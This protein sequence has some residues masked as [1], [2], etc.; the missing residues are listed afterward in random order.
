LSG[1][2]EP[3]R[4]N[5]RFSGARFGLAALIAS[6]IISAL[7]SQ[8]SFV[9]LPWLVLTT[10]GDPKQMGLVI[11]A[12][13]IPYLLA[14]IFGTPFG[15]R[16]GARRSAVIADVVSMLTLAVIAAVPDVDITVIM[17]SVAIAG[18]VR[19]VGDRSKTVLLRP[20]AEA[21]GVQISRMTA[22][23]SA[24]ANG[25]MLVGAPI[26]GLLIYWLGAQRALWVDA[27]S[28]GVCAL[29][30]VAFVH[31]PAELLPERGQAEPYLTAVRGGAT[32]LLGDRLLL[33]MIGMIFLTNAVNQANS[34]LFV[35]LWVERVLGS[36]A[37]LG[38]IYGAFG[39]GALLGNLVFIAL[40][41]KLPKFLTFALC[42]AVS[43]APRL[44]ALAFSHDLKLVL[45]L[46]FV[47]GFAVA[48]VN[49]ILG[50][51]LYERVPKELQ[52][53]VFGVAATVTFAGFPVGG[54]LGGWAVVGLGLTG[55]LLVGA[56][57]YLAAT[58]VPLLRARAAEQAA[59]APTASTPTASTT[60]TSATTTGPASS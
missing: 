51:L 34:A 10:T 59:A 31:P 4:A 48:G 39:A 26:A 12:R 9:A 43:G 13:M 30:V 54:I 52:T 29:I 16:I 18:T 40:A 50:V 6:G 2:G 28:F 32:F 53:R 58:L 36:P 33:G 1:S 24:I 20:M 47:S 55:S 17:A 11:A 8:V 42:L 46:T 23:A 37:A 7:G 5:S 22:A 25:S 41:P 44:L 27:V 45:A 35:P 14:G 38:T 3:G 21:A 57:V 60:T 49:P 15:D 19:G 56:A